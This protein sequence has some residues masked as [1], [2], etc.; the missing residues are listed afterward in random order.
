[1]YNKPLTDGPLDRFDR[2]GTPPQVA[3]WQFCGFLARGGKKA[4]LAGAGLA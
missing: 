1:M 3:K 4:A 2:V